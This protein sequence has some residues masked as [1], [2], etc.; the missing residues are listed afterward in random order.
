MKK[1]LENQQVKSKVF[2]DEDGWLR[3]KRVPRKSCFI[4]FSYIKNMQWKWDEGDREDGESKKDLKRREG[5][6]EKQRK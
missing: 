6:K 1:R 2:E 5:K 3:Y 4:C